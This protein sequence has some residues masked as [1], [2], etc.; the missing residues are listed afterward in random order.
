MHFWEGL[1]GGGGTVKRKR[2]TI[3]IHIQ[4]IFRLKGSGWDSDSE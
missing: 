2:A 3:L 4:F 1:K